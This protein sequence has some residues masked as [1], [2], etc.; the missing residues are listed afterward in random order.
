[1]NLVADLI[2]RGLYH[3][4][5]DPH[6]DAKLRA[7]AARRPIAAY[8]GFDPTAD[9]LHVGNFVAILGL[10]YAQRNGIRPIAIVGGATGLIGDPSGKASERQLQTKDTV[11][12]NVEGIRKVLQKFLDFNHSAAPARIVNNLDWFGAMSAIDFLRDVGKHF[13]VGTMLAKDSVRSRMDSSEEGM[14]YTEFSYQLLQGYDF[15]RLY[16]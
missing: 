16:K 10:M 8:A 5:S 1:M 9:S 11:A 2:S 15:Y 13:R 3:Q 12:K 6:L 7:L 14:S 4:A